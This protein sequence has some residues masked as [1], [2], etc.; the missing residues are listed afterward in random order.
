MLRGGET[1]V[2]QL[3]CLGPGWEGNATD[4]FAFFEQSGYIEGSVLRQFYTNLV[5]IPSVL[6]YLQYI[7]LGLSVP[8]IISAVVLL[9][10]SQ[11]RTCRW[12][13]GNAVGQI[14]LNQMM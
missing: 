12:L 1:G 13:M 14:R 2:P 3:V 6:E 11:V 10:M 4:N 9:A 8:L 5:L 7:F